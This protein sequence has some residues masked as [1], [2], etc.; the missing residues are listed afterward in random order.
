MASS[1]TLLLPGAVDLHVH[2]RQPSANSAETVASGTHAALL[3]GYVLLGDMPNNPKH[4]TWTEER[5]LEKHGII[6][7]DADIPVATY[8][9]SQ[10]NS[11]NISELVKM[12]PLAIG[13]KLYGAPT[14]GNDKDYSAED[15]RPIVSEWHKA[16]PNKPVMFHAGKENL[17]E[18]IGMVA[19]ELGHALHVC[20]VND[21]E[22][23]EL[24]SNA[25]DTGLNVT[26]GVCP[27]HLFKTSH[28]VSTQGW[29]ARMQPPLAAQ[30]D[31]EA[32]FR[33]LVDGKIDV[34]E[35]DHAPHAYTS[36]IAAEESNPQGIHDTE[37]T[38]CFGVPG[39]EFAL[40]LLLYQAK[41][42]RITTERIVEVTSSKPAEIF[43]VHVNSD[44]QVAWNMREYRIE[45]EKAQVPSGS[46][47][48]PFLGMLAVGEVSSVSI[49]GNTVFNEGEVVSRV[50]RVVSS[51][52]DTI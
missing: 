16:D 3:G 49:F 10:P 19:G 47:W 36:K 51:R 42:G 26:C 38:T 44:T 17:E 24:I 8:A 33:Q 13:L 14:T 20:H 32:L 46:G 43:G 22:D 41:R 52:G 31:A 15:F 4:E 5:I 40:P 18:M 1:E 29:F 27:H 39:I 23:V 25:K 35:T 7:T 34:V 45:D 11:D 30:T 50:G 6:D 9:G 12:A 37:H 48:T 28:D 21:P 2:L